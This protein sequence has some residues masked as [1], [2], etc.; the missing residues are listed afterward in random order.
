MKMM[1]HSRANKTHFHK[2]GCALRLIL[3]VR[4]FGTQKWPLVRDSKTV[5]YTVPCVASVSSPVCRESWD[6]IKKKKGMTGEGSKAPRQRTCFLRTCLDKIFQ[7]VSP[8]SLKFWKRFLLSKIY[9]TRRCGSVYF[10]ASM[11]Y[12]C[13]KFFICIRDVWVVQ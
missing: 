13:V 1:F 9:K 5:T 4:V 12:A 2:K 7:L 10:L 8:F 6:E 11:Y 3:K